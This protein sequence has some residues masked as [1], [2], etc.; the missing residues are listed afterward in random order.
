M[1]KAITPALPLQGLFGILKPSGPTS[2]KLLDSLKPL[3][4]E[5][6]LFITDET[7][8]QAHIESRKNGTN[9]KRWKRKGKG[10]GVKI[11]QGGTLDPLADGV[12]VVGVNK[13]TKSLSKFLDCSK[14]YYTTAILGCETDTYDSEGSI[15]RT[16]PWEHVTREKVVEALAG[17]RGEISQLPPVYSALKMDGK[18]LYEYAREGKPLPRPIEPRKVTVHS[19]ELIDWQEAA[20]ESSGTENPSSVSPSTSGH[21]Y[22]WPEKHLEG[23]K[24]AAM[25]SIRTLIETAGAVDASEPLPSRSGEASSASVLPNPSPPSSSEVLPPADATTT[26]P[27]T[28]DPEIDSKPT[29]TPPNPSSSPSRTPP[30]FTLKMTVS[31]GTY[32]RSIVHDVAQSLGSAA[33]VVLLSRTRQGEWYVGEDYLHERIPSIA[34]PG[35]GGAE[36]LPS[37]SELASSS[38]EAGPEPSTAT[39]SA[40]GSNEDSVAK[41][42]IPWSVFQSAIEA[43]ANDAESYTVPT[44]E[45]EEWEKMLLE[46]IQ[47]P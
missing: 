2:M 41:V 22:K 9:G 27:S 13:G 18:P 10:D 8:R 5:S 31:S 33:H 6:P 4:R 40:E 44:G 29:S 19:L 20:S 1:P 34:V 43:R 46:R 7:E 24:L 32:V 3:F 39:T 45:M 12:L 30:V 23:E 35:L 14:E 26:T 17:F 28:A 38:T 25:A 36:P 16:T 21:G 15:V 37:T 11:G 47:P 42:S